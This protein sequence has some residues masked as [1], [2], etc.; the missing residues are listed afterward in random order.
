MR[1]GKD[2]ELQKAKKELEEIAKILKY[3][4]QKMKRMSLEREAEESA[5]ASMK[6]YLEEKLDASY[7]DKLYALT[8]AADAVGCLD[9]DVILDEIYD[10]ADE[11][12]IVSLKTL[13]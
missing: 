6:A 9:G 13:L 7:R 4:Q 2:F 1:N 10:L 5:Y 11:D 12:G 8:A 3:N